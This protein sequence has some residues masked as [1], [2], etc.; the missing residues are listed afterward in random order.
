MNWNLL[1]PIFPRYEKLKEGLAH[2]IASI[3]WISGS[4]V[5]FSL[6]EIELLLL[7]TSVARTCQLTYI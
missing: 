7:W 3:P 1:I 2:T 6:I 4:L 5:R